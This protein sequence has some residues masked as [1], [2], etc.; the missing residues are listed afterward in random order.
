MAGLI[1]YKIGGRKKDFGCEMGVIMSLSIEMEFW[2]DW[3]LKWS[4]FNYEMMMGTILIMQ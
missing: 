4:N 3:N 1:P 2:G